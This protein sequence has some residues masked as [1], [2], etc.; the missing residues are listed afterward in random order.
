L[1]IGTAAAGA[2]T[3]AVSWKAGFTIAPQSIPFAALL[4]LTALIC[5]IRP[6]STFG[7]R[8]LV[9][10][11]EC[12]V[13]L[14]VTGVLAALLTYAAVHETRGFSDALFDRADRALGFQWPAAY[15]FV[16]QRPW[17]DALMAWAYAAYGWLPFLVFG[18]LYRARR[19]DHLYRYVLANSL[20]LVPTIAIF[21]LVPARAAFA[22]YHDALAPLAPPL[23]DYDAVIDGLRDGSLSAIDL[24]QLNG[25][26][27]FPSFHASM[28]VLFV[29]A[30]WPGARLWRGPLVVVNA[31]MWL[32]AVPVGGHYGVDLIGGTVIAV[33]AIALAERL[34]PQSS[35]HAAAA[36]G[37]DAE[38]ASA[39]AG[40]VL[41]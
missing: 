5:G 1:W 30:G 33:S 17:L 20:A 2:L 41:A 16:A 40:P 28:A 9:E 22:F 12:L 25:L 38:P 36:G 8:T 34:A 19:I 3:L 32:S 7:S 15:V 27:T 6:P 31:L 23:P 21:W 13:L 18:L 37:Q 26:I 10:L 29:W 24:T 14:S 39:A 4:A 35:R 11:L